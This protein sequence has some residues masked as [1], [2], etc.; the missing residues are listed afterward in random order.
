MRK[1]RNA[2]ESQDKINQQKNT[3]PKKTEI[4]KMNPIN[5]EAEELR[6]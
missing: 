4:L 2:T 5:S 3:L 1:L 6:K